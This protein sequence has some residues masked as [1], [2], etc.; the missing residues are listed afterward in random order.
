MYINTLREL[1]DAF[2][3]MQPHFE[4]RESEANWTARERSISK[5]RKLT[6]GNAPA[7]FYAPFNAGIK[8]LLDGILKTVNSL[9]TTLSTNGCSLVQDLA[10]TIGPGLDPMVEILLQNLIKL[11]AATKNISKIN[12]NA[13]VD[14]LFSNVSYNLRIMQHV[15]SA[16]QD[17][18]VKPRFFAT[19]WLS[20]IIKKHGHHKSHIEHTGGLE[21]MEK[22]IK[23]GLSDADIGVRESMRKTYW[24]FA[25]A[26]PDRA[27]V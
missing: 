4:G 19:G 23:K 10:Q 24:T 2:R 27:E 18:N 16:L 22:S 13:T 14:I 5:L 8:S 1:E 17:K 3:E 20:T 11:C 25:K 9:R 12:G 6:K 21:Y 7:A 15:W 26:W